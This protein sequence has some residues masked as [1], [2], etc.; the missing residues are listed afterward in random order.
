MQYFSLTKNPRELVCGRGKP[1][2]AEKLGLALTAPWGTQ[3]TA[4][5][6]S[7]AQCSL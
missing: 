4:P 7:A 6:A 3:L 2:A 5:A 1:P